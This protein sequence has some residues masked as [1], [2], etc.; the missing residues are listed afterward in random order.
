MAMNCNDCGTALK[1]LFGPKWYCPND[2]DK[3]PK[4]PQPT[5]EVSF[6]PM[7]ESLFAQKFIIQPGNGYY[8]MPDYKTCWDWKSTSPA[9]YVVQS[10]SYNQSK[11]L[12]MRCN[13]VRIEN[14]SKTEDLILVL[15]IVMV[16]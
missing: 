8:F 14:L 1:H 4:T 12:W 7:W 10:G 6:L 3:V 15:K 13:M 11:V 16:P 5:Y 2:C 9:E